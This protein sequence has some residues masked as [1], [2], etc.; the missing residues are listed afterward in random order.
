MS[1]H[2]LVEGRKNF[3]LVKKLT[4]FLGGMG[5]AVWSSVAAWC[6]LSMAEALGSSSE[7]G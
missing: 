6:M 1:E 2:S 5:G 7:C 4:V 3:T